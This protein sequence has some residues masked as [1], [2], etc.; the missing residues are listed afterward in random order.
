MWNIPIFLQKLQFTKKYIVATGLLKNLLLTKWHFVHQLNIKTLKMQTFT[1]PR[2][3]CHVYFTTPIF[4]TSIQPRLFCHTYFDTPTLPRLLYHVFFT[5][6]TSPRLFNHAWIATSNSHIF[7]TT[8]F[9]ATYISPRLLYHGYFT[10]HTFCHTL[11]HRIQ[12]TVIVHTFIQ[13]KVQLST[14]PRKITEISV[15]SKIFIT[16]ISTITIFT[17]Q[18]ERTLR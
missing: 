11:S 8:P 13:I 7:F 4:A 9:F 3:L 6:P 17:F 2:L 15:H 12:V 14:W 10:T 1:S 18:Y 16:L 5:T